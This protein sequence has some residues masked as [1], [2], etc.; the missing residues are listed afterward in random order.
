MYCKNIS[1]DLLQ[2]W[3]GEKYPYLCEPETASA[4]AAPR[5]TREAGKTPRMTAEDGGGRRRRRR[6]RPDLVHGGKKT[7]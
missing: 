4:S 6:E 5:S 2:I 7:R 3:G 1:N